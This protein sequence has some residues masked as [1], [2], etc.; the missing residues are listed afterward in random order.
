MWGLALSSA[1][2]FP[3]L[4]TKM[5]TKIVAK[6]STTMLISRRRTT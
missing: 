4:A 5:K 1:R 3:E 6:N 2:G